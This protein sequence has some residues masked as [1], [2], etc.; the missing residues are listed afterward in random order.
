MSK[1]RV[2]S[3]GISPP[4]VGGVATHILRMQSYVQSRGTIYHIY[5]ESKIKKSKPGITNSNFIRLLEL[6]FRPRGIIH[7]HL[8][9]IPYAMMVFILS[10]KHIAILTI[11][12]QTFLGDIKKFGFIGETIYKITL[13]RLDKVIVTSK[14]AYTMIAQLIPETKVK[15]IPAFIPPQNVPDFKETEILKLRDNFEYLLASYTYRFDFFDGHD[16][17]GIDQLVELTSILWRKGY[18]VAT[19]VVVVNLREKDYLNELKDRVRSKNIEERFCFI[20]RSIEALGFWK[21]ADIFFR[22]TN[23]DG[24]AT[25][26]F[27]ALCLG[28]PVVA[29]DSDERPKATVL[30]KTRDIEDLVDKTKMVLDN[31]EYHKKQVQEQSYGGYAEELFQLY[32]RLTRT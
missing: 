16:L 8:F 1:K 28:T 24:N 20:E 11:H 5:D 3:I 12:N 19:V 17:Y 7:N 6:L 23:S 30:V 22:L 27:E 32:D 9:S 14:K 25:S 15:L 13:R 2:Y 31:M 4:P 18:D 26:V 21:T 10:F 29:S